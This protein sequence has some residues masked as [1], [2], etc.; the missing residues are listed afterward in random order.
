MC[1]NWNLSSFQKHVLRYIRFY[2]NSLQGGWLWLILWHNGP[3]LLAAQLV[4]CL[5]LQKEVMDDDD[6]EEKYFC[7]SRGGTI[8]R[9]AQALHRVNNSKQLLTTKLKKV[10]NISACFSWKTWSLFLHAT[11]QSCNPNKFLEVKR[12]QNTDSWK[13][14]MNAEHIYFNAILKTVG[15]EFSIEKQWLKNW[16][17]NFRTDRTI[18]FHQIMFLYAVRKFIRCI[19]LSSIAVKS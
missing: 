6:M 1:K 8:M 2:A 7:T 15:F 11:L 14:H 10:A 16:F 19:K 9:T 18:I 13:W 3:F 5:C 12:S 4:C 17:F